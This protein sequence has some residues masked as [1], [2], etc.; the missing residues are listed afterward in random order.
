MLSDQIRLRCIFDALHADGEGEITLKLKLP[1]SECA[2][3]GL[4]P[5]MREI[6]FDATFTPVDVQQNGGGV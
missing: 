2:K 6:V 5:V 4:F 1:A 3:A